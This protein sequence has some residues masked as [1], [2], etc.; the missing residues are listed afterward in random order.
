MDL[1][2]WWRIGNALL[3]FV[4]L[5]YLMLDF[6]VVRN[7]LNSRRLYFT[8]SLAG[9]LLAVG[10]G[11]ITHTLQGHQ[12]GPQVPL[13]T[14]ACIWCLAGLWVSRHDRPPLWKDFPK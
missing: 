1:V 7:D 13:Y 8:F 9:L 4:A 14:A 12:M 11:S 2:F 5:I 10:V 3:A 6:R